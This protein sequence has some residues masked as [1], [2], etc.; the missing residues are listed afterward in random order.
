MD[1]K[2]TTE[3][4]TASKVCYFCEKTGHIKKECPQ[5]IA[6]VEQRNRL[7]ERKLAYSSEDS[8]VIHG[9]TDGGSDNQDLYQA[10]SEEEQFGEDQKMGEAQEQVTTEQSNDTT[11]LESNATTIVPI[12]EAVT[13]TQEQVSTEP[14]AAF[15]EKGNDPPP[16]L[17]SQDGQEPSDS[18]T[19]TLASKTLETD[20]DME[21]FTTVTYRK[22]STKKQERTPHRSYARGAPY[23]TQKGYGAT[24]RL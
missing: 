15:V 2:V 4:R 8:A 17:H 14:A 6:A 3:W 12:E 20:T 19:N 16:V 13:A 24:R 21:G 7:R 10:G 9:Q 23:S 22:Q 1:N 18:E 5:F 11:N